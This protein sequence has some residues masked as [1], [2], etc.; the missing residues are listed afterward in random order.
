[1]P[2]KAAVYYETGSPDVFRYEDVPDPVCG[3][4]SVLIEVEAISIEGGDTLNRLGG[5]MTATPHIVGYQCAGTIREVADDV[6]DR[7]V[8]QRVVA[9]MPSGSHAEL[10]AV[11]SIITWPVPEGADLVEVACVP[12]A[13]G[14]AHD[15]LFEFGHLEAGETVLIQAGAGGVGLAAI[16][17]A[18]RAGATV[19]ATAS[20]EDRLARLT[21]LGMNHGVDYSQSGWV[22]AVRQLTGGSGVDLVVD[23]V[24]GKILA[25]SV[26]CLRYRGRAITV[27]SAGRDPQPFDVS[28]LSAGNQS[29]TGV[30]LGAE[31]LFERARAMIGD[32]VEE[33]GRGELRVVVDRTFPLAEAAAAH[34]YIESRQ[35]VGRVV[36]VP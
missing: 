20:S 6:T 17:L 25:G 13:F 35:A 21:E 18:K 29:I 22:D 36:L 14:T 1:V 26:Q 32:L 34:A 5:E 31:M 3:P 4:G 23:S 7:T 10:V 27:G 8:G 9:S 11:P 15:C 28:V 12:I 30:F 16:Q 19:I 24:G 2:E 33:V